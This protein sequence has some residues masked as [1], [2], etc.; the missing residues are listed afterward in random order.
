MQEMIAPKV[1]KKAATV[2]KPV[3]AKKVQTKKIDQ[4]VF[5]SMDEKEQY[6]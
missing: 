2:K 1:F 4:L 3:Q 6:F 5:N